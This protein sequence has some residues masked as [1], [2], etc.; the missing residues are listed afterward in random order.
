VGSAA[1][2]LDDGE[3]FAVRQLF[4]TKQGSPEP[5]YQPKANSAFGWWLGLSFWFTEPAARL[6]LGNR[7]D[8]SKL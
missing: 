1:A 3:Y 4:L 2:G 5:G 7:S 8:L 6:H